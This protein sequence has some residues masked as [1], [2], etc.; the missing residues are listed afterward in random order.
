MIRRLAVLGRGGQARRVVRAVAEIRAGGTDGPRAVVLF[1]ERDRGAW[2]VRIADESAG[3]GSAPGIERLAAVLQEV[4]ADAV[5]AMESFP[6][7]LIQVAGLCRRLDLA[8]VGGDAPALERMRDTALLAAAAAVPVAGEA[9]PE[10]GE[11]RV[12]VPVVADRHGAVWTLGTVDVT[13]HGSGGPVVEESPCD[14][15]SHE[16]R[17]VLAAAAGAACR[18][19]AGP[20]VAAVTFH[21]DRHG[22]PA[23]VGVT[24][25]FDLPAVEMV[26]GLDLAK[27][28]LEVATG[29]R[30]A[31]D[32]PPATGHAICGWLSARDPA[33]GGEP[34]P[35]RIGLLRLPG[36]P[37]I[38]TD[39]AVVE[40]DDV[41]G[42]DDLELVRITAWGHDRPE[43]VH[44]LARA[45]EDTAVVVDGGASDRTDVL[46]LIASQQVRGGGGDLR[47]LRP[48]EALVI[49]AVEAAS[50]DADLLRERF[51]ASAARGRPDVPEAPGIPVQL[52]L[53]PATKSLRVLRTGPQQQEVLVDGVRVPV[54]VE[55][56][57][58]YERL[59]DIAGRQVRGYVVT[60]GPSLSVE[61]DGGFHRVLRADGGVLRAPAPGVVVALPVQPGA[62]VAAGETVAVLEMMKME[63]PVLA[64]AAGRVSAVH[65]ALNV[66]VQPRAPLVDIDPEPSVA[67]G[68][69]VPL[70]VEDLLVPAK[71]GVGHPA[72]G[73]RALRVF[74]AI[75]NLALGY[76]LDAADDTWLAEGQRAAVQELPADL[77]A[78]RVAEDDVLSVFTSL[79][80]LS[81]RALDPSPGG[82]GLA[83]SPEEYLLTY[84]RSPARSAESLPASYLERLRA[85][86]RHYG[87]TALTPG[88][89]VDDALLLLFRAS[90]RL[91][92]VVPY[93]VAVLD[94]R[95]GTSRWLPPG[96]DRD[97]ERALL[98][99]LVDMAEGRYQT[100][101]DL[102]REVRF[103][104][105]DEPL[106][107]SARAAVD[108]AAEDE[109]RQLQAD[110]GSAD[111]ALHVAQLV[112][113]P[114]PLRRLLLAWYRRADAAGREVALEATIRRYYRT[115][116]LERLGWHERDGLQWCSAEYGEPAGPVHLLLACCS[117]SELA[118]LLT[119]VDAEL[120]ALPGERRRVI[121][122]HVWHPGRL[123]TA[124][125]ADAEVRRGLV[126][127]AAAHR[128]SVT[129][130]E[131]DTG[132]T[133]IMADGRGRTYHFTYRVLDGRLE[134]E[135]F[136]RNLH[137]ML[138]ERLD[139]PRLANFTLERLDSVE[140]VYL[141][142]GVARDNPKD[143]RLFALAEVRDLTPVRDGQGRVVSL[144]LMERMYLEALSAIRRYQSHRPQ[145]QR[146]LQNQL[147]L[148]VRPPWTV[149]PAVW[150]DLAGRQAAAAGGLGVQEVVA[151]VRIPGQGGKLRQQELHVT[152]MGGGIVVR[153]GPPERSPIPVLTEFGWRALQARRRGTFYPY[154]IIR[155]L[156]PPAGSRSAL[157]AGDFVE[158]DLVEDGGPQRLEPVRRPPGKNST[159]IVVGV[160]RNITRQYPEGMSRVAI[161]GD[162]TRGMGNLAE[163]ECRRI[164]AACDLAERMRVPVEWFAVSAGAKIAMS[165]GTE[166]MDWIAA[167]LR[168]LIEFTQA[169]SE[170]N[171]VVTGINVGAQPYW[172]AEATMLMHTKG[173]LVMIP[174]SAM[175]LTGKTALDFSGG[176]S[177]EDNLGI[178]GY[179]RVMGPNGQ[180]QYVA[181]DLE[182]ACRLLFEH[183]AHAYVL[184]GERFP[185]RF[186]TTDPA[187]R[188]VRS[189]PHAA[190]PGSSFRTVGDVFAAETNA[191]RKKPFDIRSVMRAVTDMDAQ[192]LERWRGM[193][194][195]E[196][197]VVW[198]ARIGGIP[199]C[200]LGVESRPQ[201]REGALPADGPETWTSGTLFPQSSRK[202][203][204]AVNAASG[205]RPVVV[206]ANL[207]GFDGSPE[208]M[209]EWQLEYGAEIGRA[210]TNFRGP[211]VF[212]VVSRY[213]GGAFV[214]FSKRLNADLEVAAVAGSYASVIGG[215]PAAAVVFTRDVDQRTRADDR[216]ATLVREIAA[217]E[218]A[219]AERLRARLSMVTAGVRAEK[220][221]EVAAE[222]EHVHTIERARQVGSV[223]RIIAPEQLR[224][225]LVDALE[226][227]IA[228]E[229][230]RLARSAT[231]AAEMASGEVVVGR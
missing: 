185:R 16:G 204:R 93:V 152:S 212:V 71:A 100:V 132:D 157:P 184:P 160:L 170:V 94:R 73:D 47:G 199:V 205:N 200:L 63:T 28:H 122:L 224:P 75:K 76:D 19:V 193:R 126:A 201:P 14:G 149:P 210:V 150:E 194:D 227:G 147:V 163:G 105:F 10:P 154:E 42:A 217:A 55:A 153:Q 129:I 139:L 39:P 5:W 110:P 111:R 48:A 25:R 62:R 95:L 144:P 168:R 166:N 98:D 195:A 171:V 59:V 81:R 188:D 191:D 83:R 130:S 121:D 178:G 117:T 64:P 211:I 102:A 56:L 80:A 136:Y 221:G 165:S 72:V 45:L 176:V 137:P 186:V 116:H 180:A 189:F 44:R 179:E 229:L 22:A 140:D 58:R 174:D 38:R 35:G 181:P 206:L 113:C 216:V 70:A 175:V 87:V 131:D 86:L 61:I 223:D 169:G 79:G 74:A 208:S 214:V 145:A 57:G 31:G 120:R 21:V 155:M 33:A 190:V 228:R 158:Y 172:N 115:R 215:A 156:T 103:R 164:I 183:Y 230:A 202:T 24:P 3:L 118:P 96:A 8:C 138:A 37:G 106:L 91:A 13:L 90:R 27:L 146:L 213:H 12:V 167:V 53:G 177:A 109:L 99:E 143:E 135:P 78:L 173:I 141:F 1:A 18:A 34:A 101:A 104:C 52:R 222:F 231:P 17:R 197:V 85:A 50:A 192:P 41:A 108:A 159:N 114:Q 23:L 128:I 69:E 151:R 2:P 88:G 196:T 119:A 9:S 226:R 15:L 97:A 30:L 112:A 127:P 134:E 133:G 49:A 219:D 6:L 89:P 203:A 187:G 107:E 7:D 77:D 26:T 67:T 32:P 123:D 162:P 84:L 46:R 20:G 148:Y 36:G 11:R 125:E 29:G 220:L 43:A 51:F 40:G 161:F 225:Y 182:S 142:R 209:R 218:P 82:A 4:G 66:Q 198:D 65:A 207:S 54:R 124:A 60:S 68:D 92:T